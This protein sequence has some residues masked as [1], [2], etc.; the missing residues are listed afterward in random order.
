MVKHVELV[1][2]KLAMDFPGGMVDLTTVTNR[3]EITG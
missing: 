1:L 2:I 3:L